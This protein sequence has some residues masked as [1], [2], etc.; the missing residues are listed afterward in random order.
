MFD[1]KV[2]LCEGD[3]RKELTNAS[4]TMSQDCR[5]EVVVKDGAG[6]ETTQTLELK[7]GNASDVAE[8]ET[9][10]GLILGITVPITVIA[11]GV[12]TFVLVRKNKG[13]KKA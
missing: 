6:N 7:L 1:I 5:I 4:F 9:H 11:L 10:L 3:E 12:M 2:Y 8:N 13:E